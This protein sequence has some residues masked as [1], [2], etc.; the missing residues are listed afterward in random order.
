MT[1]ADTRGAATGVLR[2]VR[3]ARGRFTH[4]WHVAGGSSR[5]FRS[6]LRWQWQRLR[7]GVEPH[8]PRSAFTVA[9]PDVHSPLA[10][11][12]LRMTWVGHA[13][14]LIQLGDVCVL[15]DP[16]WSER[17]SP[18]RHIGPRRLVSAALPFDELPTVDIVVLSHD[19]YD[20]LDAATVR[21]LC[22][23]F[24]Q[25]QWVTPLGY[26]RWLKRRGASTVIELDWWQSASM[27]VPR[28][29]SATVAI[30]A[31]PAQHWTRRTPFNERVRLWSSFVID[32]APAGRVFFG[33]DSGYFEGVRQIGERLGPFDAA[34]LPIGAYEPRW[35]MRSAHMN[36]DEAV[37]TYLDLGGTGTFGAMHWGTFRLTD[38]PAFEPPDRLRSAWA[39][40]GLSEADLWIPL[41]GESRVVRDA[42]PR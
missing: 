30:T 23:R 29:D 1:R 22:D 27:R 35:F 12:E 18:L 20:H 25:L 8:P 21:R 41:H 9:T 34:L 40:H 33:G 7:N 42:Q 5:G 19:H 16:V 13:S 11:D 28:A 15:T 6:L 4:P 3:D 36:P 10:A 24:D 2:S 31:A 26:A 14:F 32:A 38:E 39:Q 37:R 17:A